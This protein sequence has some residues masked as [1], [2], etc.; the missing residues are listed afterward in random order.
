MGGE[1]FRMKM[2]DRMGCVMKGDTGTAYGGNGFREHNER[3]AAQLLEAGL[4]VLGLR[5]ANLPNMKKN[6]I[7]KCALAWLI[8][9]RTSVKTAWIKERLHMGSATN[10]SELLKRVEAASKGEPGHAERVRVKSIKI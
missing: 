1:E 3:Q 2:L 5:A 8:R 10:F 4:D 7:E 9:R 6:S